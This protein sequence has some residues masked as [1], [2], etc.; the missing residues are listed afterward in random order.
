[1][2]NEEYLEHYGVKGMKWGVHK[3]RKLVTDLSSSR[4]KS[5]NERLEKKAAKKNICF[6]IVDP[7]KQIVCETDSFR[8]Q[9]VIINLVSNAIAYT[10]PNGKVTVSVS[11]DKDEVFIKVSD[12]GIGIDEKEFPR[13]FERFYRVDKDR[14]RESGGTG[15]G[16]AIVKHILEAHHGKI[17]IDSKLD[18]GSTF[19]VII[20]RSQ[21]SDRGK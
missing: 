6:E 11:E 19:T 13:I 2:N 8:L 17:T 10:P 12:T 21:G 18:E 16:L 15:L 4:K 1:M 5:Q 20:P 3:T 9:Q 14:S 7:K